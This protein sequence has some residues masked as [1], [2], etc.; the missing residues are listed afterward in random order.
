M[1]EFVR[2]YLTV[3]LFLTHGSQAALRKPAARR[4]GGFVTYD[5]V[6]HPTYR[7][8]CLYFRLWGLDGESPFDL[9]TVFRRLVPDAFKESLRTY[10]G[11]GGISIDVSSRAL[12]EAVERGKLSV[13]KK[14]LWCR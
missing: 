9:D 2:L 8:P 12:F 13:I 14:S 3:P 10:G 11:V 7:M 6:L 5:I 4:D 1:M